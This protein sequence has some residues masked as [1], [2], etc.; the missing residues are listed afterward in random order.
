MIDKL[1]IAIAQHMRLR[2][3]LHAEDPLLDEQAL[4]DTVEGLTNLHEIL[5]AV[6]RAA[7]TD[8]AMA[9]GLGDRMEVLQKRL[10]RLQYRAAKRREIVRDVMVECEIKKVTAPDLSLSIRPSN[11]SLVITDEGSIPAEFWV[12]QQPRLNR[13]ELLA[14]L[15]LGANVNG[16]QLSNPQPVL[17]VRTK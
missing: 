7:L 11:P 3:W 14:L 5:A 16:V 2:E 13:Q 4:A 1:D 17:V 9:S 8:E 6:A 12:P 10:D 15:K